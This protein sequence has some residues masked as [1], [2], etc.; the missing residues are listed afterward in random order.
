M[1]IFVIPASASPY[2]TFPTTP[3]HKPIQHTYLWCD[4]YGLATMLSLLEALILY[5]SCQIKTSRKKSRSDGGIWNI[6][7]GWKKET[8]ILV[9]RTP[10]ELGIEP[11]DDLILP[12]GKFMQDFRFSPTLNL[13]ND[14]ILCKWTKNK[15]FDK[16]MFLMLVLGL[17]S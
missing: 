16:N 4:S 15:I 14:L 2:S 12:P 6:L 9:Q 10:G 3:F 13:Y 11:F 17:A 5:S 7:K 8:C 1:S